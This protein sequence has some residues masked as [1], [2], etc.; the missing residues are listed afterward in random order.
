MRGR[1]KLGEREFS[2]E[3]FASVTLHTR[4]G[5]PRNLVAIVSGT[6][7]IGMRLCDRLPY[8]VS[9]VA[10][11]DVTVL[12][13]EVLIDGLPGIVATGFFGNDGTLEKGEFGFAE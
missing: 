7:P 8:F 4:A 12:S 5:E 2:S 3:E 1:V 6:G 11:P 9:G 13:P 10:Y